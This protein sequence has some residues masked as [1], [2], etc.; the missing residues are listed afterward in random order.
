MKS[1]I[2]CFEGQNGLFIRNLYVDFQLKSFFDQLKSGKTQK[3][4]L[5]PLFLYLLFLE[6][7]K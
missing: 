7:L 6:S 5:K 1:I 3:G 4:S 2:L